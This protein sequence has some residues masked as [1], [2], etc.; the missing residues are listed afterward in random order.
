MPLGQTADCECPMYTLRGTGMSIINQVYPMY[1]MYTQSG[2]RT[3]NEYPIK[4]PVT[5]G[6]RPCYDLAAT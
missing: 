2:P 4:A 3:A 1:A 6:L 5:P